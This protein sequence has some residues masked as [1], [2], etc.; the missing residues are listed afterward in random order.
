M[1]VNPAFPKLGFFAPSEK[2]TE[3]YFS[4]LSTLAYM[5]AT[6][7]AAWKVLGTAIDKYE[8]LLINDSS[9]NSC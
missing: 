2:H 3:Q 5:K 8:N 7:S 1:Q 6:D 9:D 4:L